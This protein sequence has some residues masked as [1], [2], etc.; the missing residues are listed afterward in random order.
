MAVKKSI[1]RNAVNRLFFMIYTLIVDVTKIEQ[2]AIS[3][4]PLLYKFYA[5]IIHF[6]IN[7]PFWSNF[8]IDNE[9]KSMNLRQIFHCDM[10][11]KY[12]HI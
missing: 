5:K 7:K 4:V 3:E 1:R 12:P 6:V 11:F 8:T 10:T 2:T 9:T